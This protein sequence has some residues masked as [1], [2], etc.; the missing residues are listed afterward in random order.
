MGRIS[1]LIV[2]M[3]TLLSLVPCSIVWAQESKAVTAGWPQWRGPLHDG[4]MAGEELVDQF[5]AAGPPVLWV[6]DLGQG[7]SGLAVVDRRVYTM[8]QALYEQQLVCLDGKTGKT[9]W[10]TSVGWPYDGGGLYPGPRSTPTV[11]AGKVYF[12]TPQG[13]VGC[14][15]AGDGELIWKVDFQAKFKGR[16]TEFGYSCS[17]LVIGELVIL[18]VGGESAGVIALS[19]ADGSLKW[20]AGTQPA[21]YATAVPVDWQGE[22]LVVVLMQ[23][24]LCCVHRR[25][26]EQWWEESLSH[27]YDEH[28]AA[29]LYREP[30]LLIS[31]PFKSGATMYKLVADERTDRCKPERVWESLQLSNDVASSVLSGDAIYGFDLREAQSRLHRPSRGTFRALDWLTGEVRWSSDEPAHAQLIAADGKLIGF[32]DKGEVVL[33]RAV[34]D[35][36]QELGRVAVFPGEVCWTPPAL[37]EGRLYLRTQS[38]VACLYL[39]KKPLESMTP[40][41]VAEQIA[42]RPRLDPTLLL[43][44]ER[45]YPATKPDTLEF[46]RWYWFGVASILLAALC[47]GGLNLLLRISTSQGAA[48]GPVMEQRLPRIVFWLIVILAGIAGS[49]V[50]HRYQQVYLFSWPVALWACYQLALLFSSIGGRAAFRSRERLISYGVGLLFLAS[51]ALYFHLCRWLGLAIEWC[52]LTG[53]ILSAPAGVVAD[54]VASRKLRAQWLCRSAAYLL[55]FTAYYWSAVWFMDWWL[56]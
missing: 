41:S 5:P 21:S 6:R 10:T 44:A 34:P 46:R 52:F 11:V 55:S 50:F 32:N 33:F 51:C 38:R 26:G 36:Y 47:S 39:G 53:F 30:H 2:L 31:G 37:S 16:G 29:P 20:K 4:S 28:A 8:T 18:P 17:P 22:P 35:S 42:A 45:D 15:R 1:G 25:T 7:Y 13:V 24:S 27:G 19:A 23:N 43:G 3:A 12:V 48:S 49:P 40:T 14:A 9:L 56:G 54:Y